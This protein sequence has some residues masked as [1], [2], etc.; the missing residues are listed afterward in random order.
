[1]NNMEKLLKANSP[2]G[3]DPLKA[4]EIPDPHFHPSPTKLVRFSDG[5]VLPMNRRERRANHIYGG[6]K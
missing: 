3:T 2:L 4:S 1:M 5:K 6:R